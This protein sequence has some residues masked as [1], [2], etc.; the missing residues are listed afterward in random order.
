MHSVASYQ[1][2]K[3]S[4]EE[5][6]NQAP[7]IAERLLESAIRAI[8]SE[9]ILRLRMPL[10]APGRDPA[11][12]EQDVRYELE[13]RRDESG[14]NDVIAIAWH[15]D[16]PVPLPGFR[17]TIGADWSTDGDDRQSV[18]RL[19]GTY[20]PPAG[21][22]GEVF[23]EAIGSRMASLTIRDLLRRIARK[24]EALAGYSEATH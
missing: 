7:A 8:S 20:T 10:N 12:I 23:D 24:V 19:D 2:V 3:L 1:M 15:V 11:A 9:G 5:S 17:G 4:I 22:L 21:L 14:L 18:L 13:H 6:V 16:G